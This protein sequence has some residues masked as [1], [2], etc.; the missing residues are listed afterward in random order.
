MKSS[1]KPSEV[2]SVMKILDIPK[3]ITAYTRAIIINDNTNNTERATSNLISNNFFLTIANVENDKNTTKKYEPY[4]AKVL[5]PWISGKI[6][7][8]IPT[9]KAV[10]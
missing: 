3:T 1:F 8:V 10:I 9:K 7:L 5:C 4:R 2:V 6:K